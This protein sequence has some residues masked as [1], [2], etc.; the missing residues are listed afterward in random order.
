MMSTPS[1]GVPPLCGCTAAIARP[2]VRDVGRH[3]DVLPGGWVRWCRRV[4]TG[5]TARRRRPLAK[6]SSPVLNLPAVRGRPQGQV[7]K[8]TKLAVIVIW[9]SVT[10]GPASPSTAGSQPRFGRRGESD[11]KRCRLPSR[12]TV[13]RTAVTT[14][15]VAAPALRHVVGEFVDAVADG[16]QPRAVEFSDGALEAFDAELSMGPVGQSSGAPLRPVAVESVEVDRIEFATEE[17]GGWPPP[18]PSSVTTQ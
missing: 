5:E 17:S 7:V 14:S 2:V 6:S 15:E 3:V 18:L 10:L 11:G 9:P 12:P 8:A 13:A 4:P 16:H 1:S